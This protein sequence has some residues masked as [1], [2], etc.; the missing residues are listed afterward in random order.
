MSTKPNTHPFDRLASL[1]EAF[2]EDV[3]DEALAACLGAPQGLDESDPADAAML[4]G[5]PDASRH[6]ANAL[7]YLALLDLNQEQDLSPD[8]PVYGVPDP[9]HVSAL[10]EREINCMHD[11]FQERPS[12]VSHGAYREAFELFLAYRDKFADPEF[13]LLLPKRL[14]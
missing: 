2:A 4:A 14:S 8:A 7:R 13:V 10:L 3:T 6:S 1:Y 9:A 5:M 12:L 11:A